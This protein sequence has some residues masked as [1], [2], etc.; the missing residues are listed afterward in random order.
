MRPVRPFQLLLPGLLAV[1]ISVS[2]VDAQK[3]PM[4]IVDLIQ[5][6]GVG[7]AQVS[8]DGTQLLY[9]KSEA[10]WEANRT[11]SHIF[12]VNADGSGTV[13]LTYGEEGQSSPRW[14]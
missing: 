10:D 12:R 14:S 9:V 7:D 5:V 8:P 3:R 4:T 1:V 11:V 13:Q 2:P 6:P